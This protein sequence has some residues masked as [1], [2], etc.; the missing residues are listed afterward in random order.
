[1]WHT[2]F[3][4]CSVNLPFPK[5]SPMILAWFFLSLLSSLLSIISHVLTKASCCGASVCHNI[6]DCICLYYWLLQPIQYDEGEN[7]GRNKHTCNLKPL[8]FTQTKGLGP[9]M[10][11]FAISDCLATESEQ[12]CWFWQVVSLTLDSI[13]KFQVKHSRVVAVHLQSQNIMKYAWKPR[14][15][16][17][18]K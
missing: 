9:S 6:L 14:Q 18:Q 16:K 10:K 17:Q 4:L 1:M 12:T 7:V 13:G 11:D 5:F 15:V 8:H 2:P 3:N